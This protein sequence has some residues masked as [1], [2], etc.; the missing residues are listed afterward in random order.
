[1]GRDGA[2]RPARHAQSGSQ[3]IGQ[4][5]ATSIVYGM[6]RVAFE[7]GAVAKQLPLEAIGLAILRTLRAMKG[8]LSMP[9]HR[10]SRPSSL[11]TN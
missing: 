6:P 10:K 11:T 5:E 1:M 2:S 4:D 8:V 3:T 7:I 9:P